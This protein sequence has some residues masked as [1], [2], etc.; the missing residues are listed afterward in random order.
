[1]TN[2]T[3]AP[4]D[5]VEAV[6]FALIAFTP[7]PPGKTIPDVARAAI[8]A[9]RAYWASEGVVQEDRERAGDYARTLL[10]S[11]PEYR[12]NV[13]LSA[14]EYR[15]G[16]QDKSALTQAFATHRRAAAVGKGD[17]FPSLELCV[18]F[19]EC[20]QHIRKWSR[21]PFDGGTD[22]YSCPVAPQPDPRDA[23]VKELREAREE[24]YRAAYTHVLGLTRAGMPTADFERDVGAYMAD[25]PGIR[26]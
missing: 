17:G 14:F 13:S 19:S 10:A 3:P 2:K 11:G 1:M 16:Q 6:G 4:A 5:L 9:M 12:A 8:S 15:N 22:F 25:F 23:E 20:G 26:P 24:G 21:L 18:Q 7:L